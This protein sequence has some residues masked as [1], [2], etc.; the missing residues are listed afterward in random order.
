MLIS[1]VAKLIYTPPNL[2]LTT[3]PQILAGICSCFVF[4]LFGWLVFFML[5]ILTGV[6]WN[7]DLHEEEI[8]IYDY[9]M[10]QP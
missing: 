6:R 3:L 10:A 9:N 2:V 5:T 4:C 8:L 1:I 7:F